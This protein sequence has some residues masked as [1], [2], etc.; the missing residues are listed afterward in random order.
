M[1]SAATTL[2]LL[3]LAALASLAEP[4]PG[5]VQ[6]TLGV[7]SIVKRGR[8]P[9]RLKANIEL[10]HPLS[11]GPNSNLVMM[12]LGTGGER[13]HPVALKLLAED[14]RGNFFIFQSA[15]QTT[16]EGGQWEAIPLP[17]GATFRM[18]MVWKV[19]PPLT[20]GTYRF[21]LSCDPAAAGGRGNRCLSDAVE[22]VI[23]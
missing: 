11:G 14:S 16:S 23:P 4:A 20:P 6:A 10:R 5:P 8:Q 19:E 17:E 15:E 1:K 21:R 12:P 13:Y 2:L 18:P 9:L 7:L 22:L 3:G